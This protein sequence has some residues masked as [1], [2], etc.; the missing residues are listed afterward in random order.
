[1]MGVSTRRLRTGWRPRLCLPALLIAIAGCGG[2]QEVTPESVR[3]AKQLWT[4]A[5][6]K[7]YDLDW[8]VTGPNNAHYVVT[9]RDSEVVKVEMIR[10]DGSKG[11][12][13]PGK[14][15][16][17]GVD[18]L[19]LTMD[20]ELATCSKSERPFGQPKGSRVVMRFRPDEKLGY[21]HWYHRD[22]LGTPMSMSI[23]VN[24]LT[25]VPAT[26]KDLGPGGTGTPK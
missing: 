10:L 13:H 18:G 14:K 15:E 12:L 5:G 1:M 4:R 17:F 26:R 25:P 3:A 11:E 19:F 24:A 20:E 9:V 22:V 2:G 8:I 7:D 23:D 16:F 6:I 21:P